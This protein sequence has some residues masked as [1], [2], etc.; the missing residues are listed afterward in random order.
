MTQ[1]I[2]HVDFQL[3]NELTRVTFLLDAIECN[4]APLQA[5]M[6]LVRNDTGPGG[7]MNN[8][9]ATASFL[10]PHDPVARTRKGNGSKRGIADISSVATGNPSKNK[11][12]RSGI[13]KTGVEFR[14]YKTKEYNRLTPEQKEEL[15][16]YRNELESSGKSRKLDKNAKKG[17]NAS[18]VAE[19]KQFVQIAEAVVKRLKEK[20]SAA[21]KTERENAEVRDYILSVMSASAPSD[22]PATA[23]TPAASAASAQ[24]SSTSTTAPIP[25]A[26][27]RQS[28][29][30][31][32]KS[33]SK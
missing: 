27:L 24:S 13:G 7:K 1:C 22:T 25:P 16:E 28:I 5:A 29:L 4:D 32:A 9:E 15:R 23:S 21:D 33:S 6:A 11:Q 20:E 8:F 31:R 12:L 14:F 3:P 26:S 18:S 2:R 19:K 30:K 17:G 10:M